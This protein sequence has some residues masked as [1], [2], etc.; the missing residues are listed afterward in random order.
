[1]TITG[2]GGAQAQS[3][4]KHT[5]IAQLTAFCKELQT[6]Q[7]IEEKFG[8]EEGETEVRGTTNHYFI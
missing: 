5:R 1:M 4:Q 3:D 2:I 6:K 7:E 8:P